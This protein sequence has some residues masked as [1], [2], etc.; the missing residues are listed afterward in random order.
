MEM[1]SA[2]SDLAPVPAYLLQLL[3][4]ARAATCHG[5]GSIRASIILLDSR[6]HCA[7]G[8]IVRCEAPLTVLSLAL[9]DP[10]RRDR[11]PSLRRS[12]ARVFPS[13]ATWRVSWSADP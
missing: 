4:P 7:Q 5:H 3:T 10:S 2:S 6:T 12:D 11:F 8:D 13:K 1:T 9:P